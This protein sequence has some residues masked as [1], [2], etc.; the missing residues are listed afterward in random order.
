M[1][2]K[3]HIFLFAIVAS[4]A[5]CTNPYDSNFGPASSRPKSELGQI[6]AAY[7]YCRAGAEARAN[8]GVPD[9]ALCPVYR[10]LLA[11]I[12]E[13]EIPDVGNKAENQLIAEARRQALR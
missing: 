9:P 7:Q 13:S 8:S 3:N 1:I 10:Q 5:G 2:M 4:L 11:S 12:P 6:A